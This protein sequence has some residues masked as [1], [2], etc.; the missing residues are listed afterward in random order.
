MATVRFGPAGFDY[1][2]WAGVVYPSPRPKKF[3][4]LKHLAG[5]FDCVE[6]N[7]TF[8]RPAT[9]D[10]AKKWAERVADRPSFRFTAKLYQRFTHQRAETF[11]RVEV[12]EARAAFDVLAAE[13]KLGAVLIQFPWS[14]RHDETA[15]QWLSDVLGA[16]DGLPLVL[17]VRHASWNEPEVYGALAER[18]VGFVNID[19]PMFKNSIGPSA[20]STSP[21]GYVRVHGRNFKDWF[22]EGAGRDARYDYLYSAGELSPW[23]DRIKDLAGRQSLSEIYIVTNNHFRGK[24]PANAL[25]LESMV[26]GA[27]VRGPATLLAEYRDLLEPYVTAEGNAQASAQ[28]SLPGF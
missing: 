18:G 15:V 9:P 16:F 6:L 2:D 8:Y 4:P 3:D 26:T 12:E 25:M 13:K 1:K 10:T 21:V 19:Q 28:A 7:S 5:Y 17:E 20:I 14:F 11:T 23:A 27:K 24:A 22:R